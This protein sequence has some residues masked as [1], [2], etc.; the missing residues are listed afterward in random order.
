MGGTYTSSDYKRPLPIIALR[1]KFRVDLSLNQW[2]KW[3][4]QQGERG[5]RGLR[6]VDNE[7]V[8]FIAGDLL[9]QGI[10]FG[11]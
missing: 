9:E 2:K 3:I 1:R 4:R 10:R 5:G 11:L 8:R 7:T 6:G